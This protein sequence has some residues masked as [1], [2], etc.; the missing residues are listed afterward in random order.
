MI[1]DTLISQL[2]QEL[3]Y[4]VFEMTGSLGVNTF[5]C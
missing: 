5:K 1:L 2:R 4:E 3:T